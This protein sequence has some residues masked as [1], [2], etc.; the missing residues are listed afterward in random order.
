MW[1]IGRALLVTLLGMLGIVALTVLTSLWI[2]GWPSVQLGQQLT[3]ADL[4]NILKVGLAV[5]G[6]GAALAALVTG[7]RRQRVSEAKQRLDE[8]AHTREERAADLSQ[9]D[10]QE[11]RITEIYSSAATQIGSEKAAV[12]LAGLYSLERLGSEAPHLRQVIVNVVCAYLRMPYTIQP[13]VQDDEYQVRLAAQRLLASHLAQLKVGSVAVDRHWADMDIDLT[14]ALLFD[15]DLRGLSVRDAVFDGATFQGETNLAGAQI[16]GSARLAR[17]HMAGDVDLTGA[18]IR[19]RLDAVQAVFGGRVDFTDVRFDGDVSLGSAEFVEFAVFRNAVFGARAGF[20]GALFREG[21]WF[22]RATFIEDAAFGMMHSGA[23]MSFSGATFRKPARFGE[24]EI[25]GFAWF[26]GAKFAHSAAFGRARLLNGAGFDNVSFLGGAWFD[27]VTFGAPASFQ[28]AQF[29]SDVRFTST[30]TESA[31][32]GSLDG[33][34]SRQVD[35]ARRIWPPGW[36]TSDNAAT[37]HS[38]GSHWQTVVR[39]LPS[40]K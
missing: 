32:V 31:G 4:F 22:E 35:S 39:L 26:A 1:G 38:D 36:T 13:S 20:G 8:A 40:K 24:V 30:P 21:A 18:R 5:A 37:P 28:Q 6:G 3:T 9:R 25:E 29:A 7:Y 11:R 33:A 12:R 23:D 34:L 2:L 16:S 27:G 17:A 10:A 19:G 15:V 14:G